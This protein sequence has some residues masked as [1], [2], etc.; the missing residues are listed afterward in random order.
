M[1]NDLLF[2]ARAIFR[3]KAV[4]NELDAE[5][6]FHLE[7]S[8]EKRIHAGM[9]R[10][11]ALHATRLEFGGHEQVKEECREARGVNLMETSIQDA[12]FGLRLLRKN[13]AF[14]AVAI[15]TLALGIGANT[16]M[17][18]AL[19]TLL[20][21]PLP[22]ENV[23]R[24]VFITSLREGFDPFG[25][26]AMEYAAYRGGGHSFV[27]SGIAAPE[28]SFNVL[29]RGQPERIQGA[30]ILASYLTTLGVKPVIGRSFTPEEDRPCLADPPRQG[31]QR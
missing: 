29:R 26:S 4:E 28:R 5:L 12:R 1:W 21:R 17:F 14:T 23:E 15:A 13:P 25:T 9:T 19:N 2:R 3:R 7:Q 31:A 18:S 11:E 30:A 10:D 22:V 24:L 8:V 20:L 27:S 6:R 16:A